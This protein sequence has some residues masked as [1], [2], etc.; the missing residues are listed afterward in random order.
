[1]S[2]LKR[3]P[4]SSPNSPSIVV[5]RLGHRKTRDL[6]V[7]THC[8]LVAR[9]L[10]ASELIIADTPDQQIEDT[11]NNVTKRFGGFFRISSGKK[12]RKVVRNWKAQGG[13]II[14]LTMYG[15]PLLEIVS[16]IQQINTDLLIV[17]GAS[18]VPREIY[19]LA[20]WNISVSN[21]PHSE[22]ASLAVFLDRFFGGK[23]LK[24]SYNDAKIR[25][26]PSAK[27]KSVEFLN[28]E[29]KEK[30]GIKKDE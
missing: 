24:K 21:Q 26:L 17:V 16:E 6:R 1:M 10:G 30:F 13:K 4:P 5:L 3:H 9:A 12:W 25:I 14:H 29:I 15:L 11:V 28:D 27:N 19:N 8:A 7:T 23:E 20:D 18:K 22:I 2:D